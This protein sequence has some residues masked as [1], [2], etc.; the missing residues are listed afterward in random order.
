LID[1]CGFFIEHFECYGSPLGNLIDPVRARIHARQLLRRKQDGCDFKGVN[2]S[3]S[4]VERSIEAK[5]YP[6]LCSLPGRLFMRGAFLA[7]GILV[8][9]GVGKA[10]LVCA[11]TQGVHG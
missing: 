4:G 2:S 9:I 1:D 10:Y 11:R 7:Q 3:K 5:L 8:R 6:F